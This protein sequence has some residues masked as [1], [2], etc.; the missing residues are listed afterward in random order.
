[1]D[2]NSEKFAAERPSPKNNRPIRSSTTALPSK[3]KLA[4]IVLALFAIA[5]VIAIAWSPL[6]E[7]TTSAALTDTQG[8][9]KNP[10]I[11]TP[12]DAEPEENPIVDDELK[13]PIEMVT[14][15]LKPNPLLVEPPTTLD[16]SDSQFLLATADLA[17]KL[18]QWLLPKEQLRKWVMTVDLLAEGKLPKRYRPVDFPME[19]FAAEANGNT[20]QLSDTNFQRMQPIVNT[21]IS[22]DPSKLANYYKDWLPIL[23]KAYSELGKKGSFDQRVQSAIDQVLNGDQLDS[24]PVLSRPSVLFEY[25]SESLE[26]ASDVEKILWRMGPENSGKIQFFLR[27]FRAQ[28]N[29]QQN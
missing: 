17:P 19:K 8:L 4:V 18:G 28:L 13:K 5:I 15:V 6:K 9:E 10:A 22:I 25:A 16:N 24:P 12:L 23:E 20:Q 7:K 1:M 26:Q 2:A 27:D 11:E 29:E 21:V 14:T 3:K